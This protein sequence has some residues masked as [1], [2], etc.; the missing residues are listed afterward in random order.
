M[1]DLHKMTD[2]IMVNFVCF[3]E[4]YIKMF[5]FTIDNL[6]LLIYNNFMLLKDF[7]YEIP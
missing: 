6:L 7:T 1:V 2:V 3:I 4:K 5:K